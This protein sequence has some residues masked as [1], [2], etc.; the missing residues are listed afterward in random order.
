MFQILGNVVKKS[1]E[2]CSKDK[3]TSI[4]FPT[5]GTGNLQYPVNMTAH[6]TVD[7]IIRFLRDNPSSSVKVVKIVIHP[8]SASVS[9]HLRVNRTSRTVG[10][11]LPCTCLFYT[12][13]IGLFSVFV[14]SS[15]VLRHSHLC[16]GYSLVE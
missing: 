1:L 3:R 9:K 13:R 6:Y 11:V 2:Q 16:L 4:C 14:L 15:P 7:A 8:V 12:E 5:L 10:F